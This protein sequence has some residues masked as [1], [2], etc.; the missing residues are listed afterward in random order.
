MA[1]EVGCHWPKSNC[2]STFTS[3]DDIK[4]SI[5]FQS[6]SKYVAIF[7]IFSQNDS[8]KWEMFLFIGLEKFITW[9]LHIEH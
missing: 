3:F 8:K 4:R 6:K 1:V 9:L 7:C 2:I 5:V